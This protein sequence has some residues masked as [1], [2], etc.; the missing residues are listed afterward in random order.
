MNKYIGYLVLCKI[1]MNCEWNEVLAVSEQ[2]NR[3]VCNYCR[4]R[5]TNKIEEL[6]TIWK[7]VKLRSQKSQQRFPSQYWLTIHDHLHCSF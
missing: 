6:E 5:I 1:S 7:I 4:E 2:P 3:F